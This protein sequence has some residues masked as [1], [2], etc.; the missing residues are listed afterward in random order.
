MKN[1]RRTCRKSN[2]KLPRADAASEVPISNPRLAWNHKRKHSHNSCQL[3][4][5]NFPGVEKLFFWARFLVMLHS[6]FSPHNVADVKRHFSDI[7]V[8][9][10]L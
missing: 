8:F 6:L 2:R 4:H 10:S 9:F 7:K 1:K 5:K 3:S